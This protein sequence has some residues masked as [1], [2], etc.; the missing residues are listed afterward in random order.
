MNSYVLY[1]IMVVFVV[2]TFVNLFMFLNKNQNNENFNF[3]IEKDLS[4]R[5]HSRQHQHQQPVDGLKEVSL[6]NETMVLLLSLVG[7][8]TNATLHRAHYSK[9]N[10]DTDSI[11]KNLRNRTTGM[12]NQILE[13]YLPKSIIN[14]EKMEDLEWLDREDA[15]G[16][17]EYGDNTCPETTDRKP[18]QKVLTRWVEIAKQHNIRYFLTSGTLLGAW[19]DEEVIPYDQDMDIRIHID[20]FD[21][22]Y[23]LRQR[24]FIWESYDDYETHFYF[25][26]DWRLPYDL[27]R[28]FSCKGKHVE[29]YEGQCSFID[30]NARMIYRQWH[31]DLYAFTSYQDVVKFLPHDAAFEYKKSDI[32]PLTRC[33][34]MGIET[35]CP[36]KPTAILNKL[37]S[38]LKPT[39]KCVNKTY[40]KI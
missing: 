40:V 18:W 6:V 1:G 23:P 36:Q 15:K 4:S 11:D 34:F 22:L 24:K 28:R 9:Q 13:K 26:R 27:R 17:A 37:Y 19:R 35:R 38:S 14:S 30:P 32:F 7:K 25:T 12:I 33:M 16:F 10:V 21:K 31:L 8:L 2:F 39:R 3:R 29:E 20:D 5:Y